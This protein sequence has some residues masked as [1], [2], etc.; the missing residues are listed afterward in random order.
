MWPFSPSKSKAADSGS[1]GSAGASGPLV[2]ARID[3]KVHPVTQFDR[4]TVTIDGVTEDMVPRQRF[5][6]A[7]CLEVDGEEVEVPTRGTVVEVKGKQVVAT[8]LAPQPYYQ[9]LM[10]RALSQRAA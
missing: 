2:R 4:A 10:R 9:K 7:F 3:R 6:F 5:Q 1:G 8:Y